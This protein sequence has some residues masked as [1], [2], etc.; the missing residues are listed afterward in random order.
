MWAANEFQTHFAKS[1][2]K[3]LP[4]KSLDP[5][6]LSLG[7][8]AHYQQDEARRHGDGHFRFDR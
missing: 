6:S 8:G 5:R 3:N 2:N 4:V 7:H 1:L